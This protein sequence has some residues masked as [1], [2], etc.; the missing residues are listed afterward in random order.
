VSLATASID[1]ADGRI[2]KTADVQRDYVITMRRR[3]SYRPDGRRGCVSTPAVVIISIC[4]LY[5][6]LSL[7]L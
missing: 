7:M 4:L 3:P 1:L 2:V 5:P 6:A